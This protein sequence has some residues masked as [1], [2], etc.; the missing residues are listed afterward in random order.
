MINEADYKVGSERC[1]QTR[2]VAHLQCTPRCWL[3]LKC[4]ECESEKVRGKLAAER[5]RKERDEKERFNESKNKPGEEWANTCC[6]FYK[7]SLVNPWAAR[8]HKGNNVQFN[9]LS[10]SLPSFA[11]SL[12]PS[13]RCTGV[14]DRNL[15][16]CFVRSHWFFTS[17]SKHPLTLAPNLFPGDVCVTSLLADVASQCQRCFSNGLWDSCCKFNS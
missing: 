10:F 15:S 5:D 13:S 14:I 9:T 16:I 1:D 12:F 2:K 7:M 3:Q 6:C 11:L 8:W 17:Y 4:C